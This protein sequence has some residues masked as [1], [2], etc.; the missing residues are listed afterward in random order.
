MGITSILGAQ[1]VNE[2]TGFLTSPDVQRYR[3]ALRLGSAGDLQGAREELDAVLRT[4]PTHRT[5]KLRRKTLDDVDSGVIVPMTAVHLFRAAANSDAGRHT[6][7]LAELDSGIALNPL[8]ADA[9]R[10]RGRTRI[11][12]GEIRPGIE[13]YNRA[14]SLNPRSTAA[15]MNRGNAFLRI[16]ELDNAL[17]DFNTAIELE[18]L[19]AEAYINRGTVYVSLAPVAK[20]LADFDRAINLDPASAP[21]YA[22]KAFLYE[23]IGWWDEALET[24][25]ALVRN[26]RPGYPELLEHAKARIR[27]LERH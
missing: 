25:R 11:E 3:A 10:L 5:A 13:D 16:G 27:D 7:A 12:L 15:F 21:A 2:T 8:Y 4:D 26:S 1:N 6:E 14:I 18:P 19:N 24:H 22:N 20:A 9:F 23:Q 17:R